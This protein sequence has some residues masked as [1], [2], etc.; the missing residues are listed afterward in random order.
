[1]GGHCIPI[2]PS[3]LSHRVQ[4]SLGYPFR[5]VELAQEINR[6]MPRYVAHRAQ[7]LLND[8]EK[9]VKGS[10][11]GILGIT[12]KPGIAD[13]RESPAL[14]LAHELRTLGAQLQYFDPFVS[15]WDLGPVTLTA[16]G[17]PEEVL[18]TSDLV[19]HLQPSATYPTSLLAK[20]ARGA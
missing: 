8:R 15:H 10:V 1:M 19:V 14:P 13:Q 11:V 17:T 5:F 3:Y 2:D 6:S 18:S 9:P 12:Y 16:A 7:N 20:S 4:E